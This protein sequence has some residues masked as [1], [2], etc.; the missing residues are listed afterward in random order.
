ME[1]FDIFH[2]YVINARETPALKL[3]N[4]Y[5]Q[6]SPNLNNK[7]NNF[8]PPKKNNT[9]KTQTTQQKQTN[10]KPTQKQEKNPHQIWSSIGPCS[11]N[12]HQITP[13]EH[14]FG[15]LGFC[16]RILKHQG[17]YHVKKQLGLC[18]S[19]Q[20]NRA[21]GQK[22]QLIFWNNACLLMQ[23]QMN[24]VTKR[25]ISPSKCISC[26]SCISPVPSKQ[27]QLPFSQSEMEIIRYSKRVIKVKVFEMLQKISTKAIWVLR[28]ACWKRNVLLIPGWLAGVSILHLQKQVFT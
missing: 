10:K 9:G 16:I 24:P 26:Y 14:D 11:S 8:P 7:N 22:F 23:R 27:L 3:S 4:I 6:L 21:V 5:K 19:K 2:A 20:K 1:G 12:F 25:E 13:N 15:R 18:H 28:T 17:F